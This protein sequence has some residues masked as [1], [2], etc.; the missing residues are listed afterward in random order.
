MQNLNWQIRNIPRLHPTPKSKKPRTAQIRDHNQ[1][2]SICS[3]ST[4]EIGNL[5]LT[6]V[7]IR[8][9]VNC[10]A[11]NGLE[12]TR[13]T[14][15]THVYMYVCGSRLVRSSKTP[16]SRTET[17]TYIEVSS[18]WVILSVFRSK[19]SG[20]RSRRCRSHR[21]CTYTDAPLPTR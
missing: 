3:L 12:T 11:A 20:R 13:P 1:N 16:C 8:R 5:K 6:T 2:Q 17:A 21:G 4:P 7:R 15:Y 18:D 19:P 10:P 14:T 9:S